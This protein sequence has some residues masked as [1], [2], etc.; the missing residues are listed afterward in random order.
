MKFIGVDCGPVRL[1]LRA[2]SAVD[3]GKLRAD[4]EKIGFFDYCSKV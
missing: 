4:L 2:I 3:E 1:P